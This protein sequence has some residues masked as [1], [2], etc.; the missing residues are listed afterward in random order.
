MLTWAEPI[1]RY[2][3]CPAGH[4]HKALVAGAT[5]VARSFAGDQNR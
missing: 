3:A 5:F 1:C 4:R 2:R